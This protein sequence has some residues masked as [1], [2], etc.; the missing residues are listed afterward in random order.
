MQDKE[1]KTRKKKKMKMEMEIEITNS[2]DGNKRNP[3]R[4]WVFGGR[5]NWIFRV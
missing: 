1:K 5:E 2:D 4:I 3:I